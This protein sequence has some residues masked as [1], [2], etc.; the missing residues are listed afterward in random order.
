MFLAT[1]ILPGRFVSL[2]KAY[3]EYGFVYCFLSSVFDRGISK[4]DNYSEETVENI[5]QEISS[6][7]SSGVKKKPNIIMIQLESF[8]DPN[9]LEGVTYS[10][11][12]T[13][14]FTRFIRCKM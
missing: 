5:V 4:P 8:F 7:K 6:D 2:T 12:P 1:N 9:R 10:Q 11:D 14:N 3:R 13:P